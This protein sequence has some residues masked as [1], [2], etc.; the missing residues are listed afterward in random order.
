[1]GTHLSQHRCAV[2]PFGYLITA[3]GSGAQWCA[4]VPAAAGFRSM[5]LCGV[6]GGVRGAW[7]PLALPP[8]G[9]G[10]G[11]GERKYRGGQVLRLSLPSVP[12]ERWMP[13]PLRS[14]A[15]SPQCL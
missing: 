4:H 2:T 8:C 6:G 7:G 12:Q 5:T 11:R 9:P 1:M 15:T 3:G 13:R 10:L 14:D